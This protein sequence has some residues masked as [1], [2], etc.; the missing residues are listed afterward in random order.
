[1]K[2]LLTFVAMLSLSFGVDLTSAFRELDKIDAIQNHIN[3]EHEFY[4]EYDL[5]DFNR[6]CF[7]P[8]LRDKELRM[9]HNDR[10]YTLH[11]KNDDYVLFNYYANV[12]EL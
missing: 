7:I 2:K 10:L 5:L 12:D 9:H 8:K 6:D 11:K 4:D 1:M 3:Y